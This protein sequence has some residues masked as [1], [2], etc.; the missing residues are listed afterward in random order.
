MLVTTAMSGLYSSSEPSLSSASATK[1][2]PLP[3]WALVPA[4]PRSPPTAND[5]SNPQCCRATISIEVVVVLPWVPVTISV[6]W[7]GHQLGQHDRPQDHRD[8]APARLDQFGVGLG[9][10]GMRGDD[11]RRSTG[12]Q[13]ERG[14]VVPDA[15]RRAAGPQRHHAARLLGVRTGHQ[16]AAVQ[17]DAGDARHAGSADADHVHPLQLVGQATSRS[18]QRLSRDSRATS[19]ATS[20]TRCAASRCPASAAAAVI[21][22]SRPSSVS[23][24]VT[25][26]ATNRG[27]RSAS[28]TMTPPPALDDGQRVE[29]LLAI[30]DRQRHVHRG[31]ADRRH[32]GDRHRPRSADRQVGG[33]V[34]EVHPVQ[35]RNGDIGRVAVGRL[36]QLER[37]LRTVRVQHRDSRRGKVFGGGR[38]PPG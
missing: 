31:Q 24:P 38:R 15:D 17:Q 25:V 35:I 37:V 28:S 13:V 30:A 6:V 36:A 8:A 27:D 19:R 5:G 34:G 14:L 12:Q 10:R 33:R 29:P 32:L 11:G 4:S 16:A 22:C 20:A 21:A 23:N 18:P 9:D 7:P 2:S 1:Q 26:S 3:W